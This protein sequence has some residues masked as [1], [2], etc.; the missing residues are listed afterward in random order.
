MDGYCDS[1]ALEENW[2]NWIVA[3]STPSLERFRNNNVLFTK[4]LGKV[5]DG[6]KLLVKSGKTFPNPI[7]RL[8]MHCVVSDMP[9]LFSSSNGIISNDCF[10]I[11]NIPDIGDVLMANGFVLERP[12]DVYWQYMLN[13]I[14]MIC[15]GIAKKFKLPTDEDRIELAHE[16]LIQVINKLT[17]NKLVYIPG[18]APVFNLLTTTI[19]RCMFS[20]QN[21]KKSQRNGINK[22]LQLAASRSLPDNIRSFRAACSSYDN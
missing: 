11:D 1:A 17:R 21:R 22:L 10:T 14:N 5:E 2:Y 7:C 16:A 4:V 6:G 9:I 8:K 18:R 3:R 15:G 12:T 19:W 13:D 20:I